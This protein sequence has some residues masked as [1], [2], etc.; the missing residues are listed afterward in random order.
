MTYSCPCH[1]HKLSPPAYI[2]VA[3]FINFV[4][5]SF[6][7]KSSIVDIL[8]ALISPKSFTISSTI[9]LSS[10]APTSIFFSVLTSS[11]SKSVLAPG[12]KISSKFIFKAPNKSLYV[13]KCPLATANKPALVTFLTC[14]AGDKTVLAN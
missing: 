2:F 13:P 6:C 12:P 1:F 10:I 11:S 14:V 5:L 7:T 9:M 3:V 4:L 8:L